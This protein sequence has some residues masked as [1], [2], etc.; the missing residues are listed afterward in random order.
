M[1]TLAMKYL[2]VLKALH[3]I[4]DPA[5]YLEIGVRAGRSL[6]PAPHRAVGVDPDLSPLRSDLRERPGFDLF[7]EESDV[8]FR[9]RSRE[10]VL[11][12]ARVDFAFIDGLHHSDQVARDF[13]NVERWSRPGTIV[14][15]HDCWPDRPDM[16][17]RESC[18]GQWA[19]DCWRVVPFLRRHRPDLDLT[20]LDAGPTGLLIVRGLNPG[21]AD[22]VPLATE[23]DREVAVPREQQDREWAEYRSRERAVAP[24]AFL[25]SLGWTGVGADGED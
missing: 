15:L 23:L 13:A 5:V 3:Q 18:P 16:A 20:I 19:G 10:D 6:A 25:A 24:E 17:Y 12:E 7:E 21:A 11:G 2:K 9:R 1:L 14:A 4:L 8:F 22:I